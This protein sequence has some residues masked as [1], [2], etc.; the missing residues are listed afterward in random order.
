[1]NYYFLRS[2]S[3]ETR[4][5]HMSNTTGD[6]GKDGRMTTTTSSPDKHKPQKSNPSTPSGYTT[7]T[8]P[9]KVEGEGQPPSSTGAIEDAIIAKMKKMT[10]FLLL[11]SFGVLV[12]GV[13]GVV[14]AI[15]GNLQMLI[16]SHCL[17]LNQF[18]FTACFV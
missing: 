8:P 3:A 14:I 10:R 18:V 17:I 5:H 2:F 9:S 16:F 12:I 4:H 1:M 11:A 7:H 6:D 13:E 15:F